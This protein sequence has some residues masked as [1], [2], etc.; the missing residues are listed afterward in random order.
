MRRV[1]TDIPRTTT[2]SGGNTMSR[3]GVLSI[4]MI[5]SAAALPRVASSQLTSGHATAAAAALAPTAAHAVLLGPAWSLQPREPR[6]ARIA[7]TGSEA[8]VDLP[9]VRN[10]RGVPFMIAGGAMFLAGAVIGDD[11]GAILML[12]GIGVGAYGAYVYFGS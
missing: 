7:E 5:V 10:R 1:V 3:V 8:F 6:E 12:G 11:G 9:Q 4:V 2:F